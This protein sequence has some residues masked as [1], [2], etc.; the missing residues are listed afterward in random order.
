VLA[1][2]S[3]HRKHTVSTASSNAS[4]C[5]A[6]IAKQAKQAIKVSTKWSKGMA[7]SFA[8]CANAFYKAQVLP[9]PS[10]AKGKV[11]PKA[12]WA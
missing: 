3:K 2:H 8:L 9:V 4:A 6:C 1:S 12:S 5:F 7:R 11:L 10:L